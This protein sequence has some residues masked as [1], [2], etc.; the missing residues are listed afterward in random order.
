[1]ESKT[2]LN[3]TIDKETKE[4]LQKISENIKK[5]QELLYENVKLLSEIK[6]KGEIK[7]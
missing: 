3:I 2:E 7:N 5:V 6:L 4:I 1:M